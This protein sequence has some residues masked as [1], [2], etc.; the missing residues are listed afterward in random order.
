MLN[1]LT[2]NIRK[3]YETVNLILST[4]SFYHFYLQTCSIIFNKCTS[5]RILHTTV[6]YFSLAAFSN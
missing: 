3:Y 2:L 1:I 4:S 6:I 5:I